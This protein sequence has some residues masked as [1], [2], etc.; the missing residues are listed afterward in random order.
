[1]PV[2]SPT[3]RAKSKKMDQLALANL[4]LVEKNQVISAKVFFFSNAFFIVPLNEAN[5]IHTFFFIALTGLLVSIRLDRLDNQ[6]LSWASSYADS[7]SPDYQQLQ[8]EANKAVII[9][10]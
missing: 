10:Y 9:S 3:N 7:S 5:R 6:R 8:W 1:M 2:W 4:V